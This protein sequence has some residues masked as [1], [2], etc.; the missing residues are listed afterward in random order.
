MGHIDD[1]WIS[2]AKVLMG[3]LESP[4]VDVDQPTQAFYCIDGP[5]VVRLTHPS[6]IEPREELLGPVASREKQ[7]GE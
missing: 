3:T 6:K 2:S 7:H 4:V 1:P 5:P